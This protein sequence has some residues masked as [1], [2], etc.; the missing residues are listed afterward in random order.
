MKIK[1]SKD[2]I[3]FYQQFGTVIHSLGENGS[4]TTHLYMPM[5]I[6]VDEKGNQQLIRLG[7]LPDELRK[8]INAHR[9]NLITPKEILN[10]DVDAEEIKA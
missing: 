2:V 10:L 8:E 6:Q 3:E 5:W 1:L 4:E 9:K 7:N